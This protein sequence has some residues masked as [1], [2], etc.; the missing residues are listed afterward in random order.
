MRWSP[1]ELSWRFSFLSPPS[2]PL[3]AGPGRDGVKS[4]PRSSALSIFASAAM[5]SW[6]ANRYSGLARVRTL[7]IT[8]E[9]HVGQWQD[10]AP[11]PPARCA[12]SLSARL[13]CGKSQPALLLD[14]QCYLGHRKLAP[15]G[16]PKPASVLNA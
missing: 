7:R 4:T 13:T 5:I 16:I 12:V 15:A 2:L 10:T 1:L 3:H 11:H 14:H 8:H 6:L 9:F